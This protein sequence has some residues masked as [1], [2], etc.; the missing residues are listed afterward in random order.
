LALL[1]ILGI[2]LVYMVMAA[3]FESLLDPFIIMFAVPFTFT[4]VILGLLLARSTLNVISF[5]GVVMLMGIVVNNAIVLISYINILRARGMSMEQAITQ[6]GKERLRP[7]LMTTI[8]TLVGLLPLA[9]SRGEGSE[10]W[11]PWV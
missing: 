4:G 3:Q 7:V 1:L 11:Q 9:L 6:G 2:I 10:S 5:L 8:T